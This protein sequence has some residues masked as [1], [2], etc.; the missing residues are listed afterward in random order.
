MCSVHV[1]F[2]F[3]LVT[4]A[5]TGFQVYFVLLKSLMQLLQNAGSECGMK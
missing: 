4:L 5:S 3:G 1:N 2:D